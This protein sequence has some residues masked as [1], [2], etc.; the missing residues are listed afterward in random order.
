MKL[1]TIKNLKNLKEKKVILRCDFNVPLKKG[2]ILDDFRIKA[3]FP[4]I[5]YLLSKKAQILLISHLGDPKGKK[6]E[7]LS[8]KPIANYLKRKLG[9]KITLFKEIPQELHFS[10]K[11]EIFLLENIRFWEG[12]EKCEMEFAKKIAQ[13]GEIY[14]NEA[15]SVSHRK[16]ASVYLL[17]QL[18]P[19][20]LGLCFEKE[21]KNLEKFL[22]SPKRP[23]VVLVGGA[24]IETK[25]PLIEKFL[26]MAD[27]ILVNHLIWKE[28]QEKTPNLQNSP[29]I[30]H[31][32]D[33]KG[34]DFDIGPQTLKVF[35]EKIKTAKTIFWNGPFGKIEDKKFQEGT[36]EIAKMI[37]KSKA[38][39]LVG[40]GET[41]EFLNSLK[42]L[43]KF[44][45]VSTGGG[46]MLEFLS[47]K[48]LPGLEVLGYYG[49]QKS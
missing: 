5:K 25:A 13:L 23:L 41:I 28:I 46:A 10:G 35:E 21:I 32:C 33:K 15:F 2:K 49:T 14:V 17:P 27:W 31:P 20:Y 26:E 47:G 7:E 48:R 37:L 18:L 24:K 1:K 19:S 43:K 30:I 39:S 44:S 22:K 34:E 16:H 45:F 11:K 38:Y 9:V 36:K 12:E 3:A 4:T 40:G 29:K 6:V 42:V 8:L